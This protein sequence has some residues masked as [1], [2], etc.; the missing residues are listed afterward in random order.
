[1]KFKIYF[2][3]FLFIT[4]TI[5]SEICSY[6]DFNCDGNDEQVKI[7]R[8]SDDLDSITIIDGV[9]GRTSTGLF[10]LQGGGVGSGYIPNHLVISIDFES[11]SNPYINRLDF[12]WDKNKESWFLSKVSSWEEPFRETKSTNDLPM[13]FSVKRYSCCV[14]LSSFN[15]KQISMKVDDEVTTKNAINEDFKF[16][17]NALRKKQFDVLFS[18]NAENPK[19]IPYDF[20][21][22]LTKII[23]KE[24]IGM[25]ND[26]AFY[27]EKYGQP[28]PAIIILNGII[29]RDPE[30]VVAYLNLADAYWDIKSFD[31]ARTKYKKYIELMKKEG[32]ENK[33][34]S[35]VFERS[36]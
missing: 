31:S 20:A 30:R 18:K 23:K 6:H 1:M 27:A 13:N 9:S 3:F 28:I 14:Y 16:V 8:S 25:L 19:L 32:K 5:A 17:T 35:I 15:D 7:I 4:K 24:N 10:S 29:N 26:Y 21:Y 12:Y 34:P 36:K 11:T 33:I 2:L 22:E